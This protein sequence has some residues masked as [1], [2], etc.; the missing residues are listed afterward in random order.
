MPG[1][2]PASATTGRM[3]SASSPVATRSAGRNASPIEVRSFKTHHLGLHQGPTPMS[4]N[5][6][7]CAVQNND[8]ASERAPRRRRLE[9]TPERQALAAAHVPLARSLARSLMK[10]WPQKIE[11]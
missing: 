7:P 8:G 2:S 5:E 10:A 4:I 11:E 3:R 1:P 6:I 9:L